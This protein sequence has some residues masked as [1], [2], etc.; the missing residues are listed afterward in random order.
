MLGS[1]CGFPLV[2]CDPNKRRRYGSHR[3]LLPV[4]VLPTS[5][6][7]LSGMAAAAL[8]G[9]DLCVRTNPSGA[10]ASQTRRKGLL[11]LAAGGPHITTAVGRDQICTLQASKPLLCP[12]FPS[13]SFPLPCSHIPR[14]H[15]ECGSLLGWRMSTRGYIL[16]QGT[17]V[18]LSQ[19]WGVHF[20]VAN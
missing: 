1:A 19:A 10:L 4:P 13:V 15:G 6:T 20:L 14:L 12:C 18:S 11:A 7:L 2:I 8:L 9:G 17:T 16:K 5:C 3:T